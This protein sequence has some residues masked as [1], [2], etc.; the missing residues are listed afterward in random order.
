M[1]QDPVGW[2]GQLIHTFL[3][4]LGLAPEWARALQ[5]FL[6]AG[7]LA[8]AVLLLTFFLIWVER[9]ILARLQDR[10][11]PNRVGPYGLF[12]TIADAIKLVLKEVIVPS[13]AD[14]V[15]YFL[16]PP[17][18][19]MSVV[20]LWGVV[21]LAPKLVGADIN[22][23]VIYLISIGAIGTL[24]VM[25]A[26]WSSN[27]KY[28]LLGAFRTV[29][30]LISYEVPMVVALLVPTMLA[31]SMGT[32]EIVERQREMW[33]VVLAPIAALLFF[34]SSMAEAGKAP[35][36]LLEAESEIVAGYNI[37]YSSMA[38]GMFF[39]GEF[40]HG[41]TIAALTVALFFGGWLGPGVDRFPLLGLVYFAL[42]SAV[43]YFVVIWIRGT[44]PRL[45]ID[46]VNAFNWKFLVPL[47]L[48]TVAAT[49]VTDKLAAGLGWSRTLALLG[50]NG[51]LALATIVALTLYARSVRRRKAR[52]E[53][54]IGAAAT[55][56][57]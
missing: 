48:A 56:R 25:L 13:G 28:A 55:A 43:V 20:G 35:F 10:L 45:R 15:L 34:I 31:G 6:A 54:R 49:A 38:F 57:G 37:E 21:P 2:L 16:A 36:D 53:R 18:A 26:G 33:F 12:Q 14:R 23:G 22:V 11:G 41:F 24:A 7:A 9:K 3:V 51:V 5:A 1:T 30:M 47:S 27:N 44:L 29:A 17:L 39:V 50:V 8:T 40:L 42:K 52:A 4:S 32:V 46:Q 19:V